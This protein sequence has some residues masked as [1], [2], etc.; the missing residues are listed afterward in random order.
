M[1]VALSATSVVLATFGVRNGS[2]D[3]QRVTLLVG[4]DVAVLALTLIVGRSLHA[5]VRSWRRH[6]CS[7]GGLAVGLAMVPSLLGHPSDRGAAAIIRWVGAMALAL[8]IGSA[9]RDGFRLVLGA[10]AAVSVAHIAVAL[11]E[12]G[13]G[14]PVG[15]GMFGEPNA[16]EIG[17]R[18]ASTGLTVHP[19]VLAAW[20][21]VAGT[22][23]V[24]FGRDRSRIVTFVGVAAFGGIGLTMSRAGVLAA[25]LA[26][27][28]LAISA[29]R[30]TDR[31]WRRTVLGVA[32]AVPIGVLLN[33]SGW[34]DRASQ[35]TG[36]AE[37]VSSGRGALLRQA[38]GLLT[39]SPL[40]GV[41]PGRYVLA[42]IERP[43]LVALSSQSPRPVH[44][45]PL[46]MIVEG[47]LLVIPALLLLALAIG[48]ACLR[49]G[50][51]AVALTLA[52]LPFLALD[53][54]AW[55]YPQGILLTGLWLGALDY[56][57]SPS[58]GAATALSCRQTHTSR[59]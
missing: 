45:T 13:N 17:G 4:S 48:R 50:A 18:Y 53:H 29:Q 42:L 19:Y 51:P 43:E 56:L 33:L 40:T 21:V 14:G 6:A 5:A 31:E 58:P 55:S 38:W 44:L 46:L 26:L 1:V 7:L 8:A 15:L 36:G 30:S 12:R 3:S 10:I 22:V 41:G 54:L 9:R 23:L 57:T 2:S 37:T 32:L 16:Y 27:V 47:G 35:V 28:A 49:S 59:Y 52:M 24:I 25:V 11:A 39:D 20:C 34:L